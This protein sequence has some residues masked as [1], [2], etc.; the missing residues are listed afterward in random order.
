[1]KRQISVLVLLC[2]W[3]L[4]ILA[5]VTAPDDAGLDFIAELQEPAAGDDGAASAAPPPE[6]PPAE[7]AAAEVPVIPVAQKP[8]SPPVEPAKRPRNRLVE[9]IVV[10]AQK[11]EENLQDVPISVQAFSGEMLDALGVSDQ[12]DLQRVT[13]GL[14][15]TNQVSYVMTFLRGVG[16]DATIAA[17][18]SVATY[19]DGIYYPFASNLAQNFGAVD[20]IEVLKGPQGTLFG[21]NATGGAIAIHTKEPDPADF[22][23]ELMASFSSFDTR[24]VRGY[25]NVPLTDWLALNVTAV[26]SHT[27]GYY[28][29]SMGEPEERQPGDD[30]RG[31]RLKLRAQPTENLDIRLAAFQFTMDSVAGSA[32]FTAQPSTLGTASGVQP[33]TGYRGSVDSYPF[34]KTD[35]NTVYYGS[36]GYKAPWFD[37]KLLGSDQRMDTAGLRDFDGSRQPVS[38]FHT[39]SQFIDAQSA[40][41]QLLSNGDFGPDWLQW[42]LGAYYFR[43]TGGFG[44]LNFIVSG[45]DLQEGRIAGRALP[46]GLVDLLRMVPTSGAINLA[47]L[48]G[49]DSRA[50]FSQATF[51]M[52]DWFSLT[53]GGRWQVE[54]RHIVKST[55]GTENADG[56]Q[57]TLVDNSDRSTDSNGDPYPARDEQRNF[58][59]KLTAEFRPFDETLVYLS[60]QRAVK[61]ATYN[62]VAIYDQPDYV[63]PEEIEA[64]EVGAKTALFG[65]LARLNAAAFTYDVKNLQTYYLS[66]FAGGVISFQN[67]GRA[68]IRGLEF[69]GLVQL[70]PSVVDDLVLTGGVAWL[71]TEYKDFSDASGFDDNGTFVSGQDYSGKQLIRTPEITGTLVLSKTWP[72][73]GG[74]FEAAFDAYYTDDFYYEPSNRAASK[75]EGYWLYGSRLSY[76]HENWKLRVSAGVRN[77][78]DEFYTAGFFATDYGVQPSLAPPRSYFLQMIWNF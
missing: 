40:E 36:L 54:E 70:L 57:N 50:L 77:L 24:M 14:N 28:D 26:T 37:L 3:S 48:I 76:L 13:P 11:R 35:D 72:M 58:S 5:E 32:G 52:T 69:D 2:C 39:P 1:M 49:T 59:P 33:Q 66:L 65:G 74:P 9:E 55:M 10:T 75:Q 43:A 30:M 68:S 78:T 34:N 41:L 27:D 60:W 47:G 12:T 46:D 62:T 6:S 61:A 53:V 25:F 42:I 23:G 22:N 20:R 16:T 8:A 38:T 31:F 67:A 73:S 15:V 44:S 4:P 71:D 45:I 51:A 18:P 19:I 64:W 17:E 56:S 29:A 21:R 7:A 63:A